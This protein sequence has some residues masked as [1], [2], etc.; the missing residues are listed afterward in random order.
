MRLRPEVRKHR[1]LVVDLANFLVKL[2]LTGWWYL[3][4][5]W[6]QNHILWSR[7][8]PKKKRNIIKYNNP[9]G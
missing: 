5:Y 1:Q 6:D 8:T 9:Y 7:L 3:D 4:Q 2:D